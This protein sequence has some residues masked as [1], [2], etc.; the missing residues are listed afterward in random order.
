MKYKNIFLILGILLLSAL[1]YFFYPKQKKAAPHYHAGFYVYADGALLDFSGNE[2]MHTTYCEF[3]SASNN[4]FDSSDE[5]A[6]LHNN[7][8][9]VIHIHKVGVKWI[10]LFDSIGYHFPSDKSI[11]GFKDGHEVNNIL[12]TVV[13]PYES[14]II[15][16]G[17]I[18]NVDINRYVSKAHIKEVE[19]KSEYCGNQ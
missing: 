10:D 8:G 12:Q 4:T 1:V 5:K 19:A 14:I 6:H 18:K 16:I 17:D 15:A 3:D 9:D 2:H 13:E 7:V 11:K